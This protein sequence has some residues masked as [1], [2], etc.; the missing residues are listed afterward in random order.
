MSVRCMTWAW[1]VEGLKPAQ[2]LVLMRLADHANDEGICWPGKDHLAKKCSC[3]KR[4]V[5]AAIEALVE[6]GLIRLCR[7]VTDSGTDTSNVYQLNILQADLFQEKGQGAESAPYR[8]ETAGRGAENDET[9]VQNLQG[10]GAGIAPEPSLE[11]KPEPNNLSASGDAGREDSVYITKRKRKL[12]GARLER[13]EE[14]MRVFG[15][16]NG[17]AEA[18]DAWLDLETYQP[19]EDSLF[20][21]ILRGARIEAKQRPALVEKGL[22]PKWAQGWL[23]ARRWEDH[24][25]AESSGAKPGD[26]PWFRWWPGVLG[27][28]EKMGIDSR[29]HSEP[30]D[31]MTALIEAL[32]DQ[33]QRVSPDLVTWRDRLRQDSAA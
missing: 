10:E 6:R 7:R 11:P 16:R 17:K 22:T 8:A 14:F 29:A 31:L 27:K 5:D 4:T 25:E 18:A 26:R 30:A 19:M 15:L 21:Q 12:R 32:K 13:F 2:K 20:Q 23:T 9:R 33:D 24:L 3:S 28:A 1:D